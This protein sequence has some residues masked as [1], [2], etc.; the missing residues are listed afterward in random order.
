MTFIVGL[1]ENGFVHIGGDS[2][3]V[4]GFLKFERKDEKVFKNG[5]FIFGFTASFRMG[6]I[7]RHSFSPPKPSEGQ[8]TMNFMVNDFIDSVRSLFKSKG[9]A[10]QFDNEEFGGMFLVGFRGRLFM[11]DVDYQVS[12]SS[13]EYFAIGCGEEMALGSLFST[14][15]KKPE[16]R[17]ITALEAAQKHS[18]GVMGP[19]VTMFCH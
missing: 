7:L 16:E 4:K 17:L 10:R 12:E 18:A 14:K 9:Y 11:I 3:G 19:F 5:E 13:D 6:Q 15:G 1:V 2:A 8:D